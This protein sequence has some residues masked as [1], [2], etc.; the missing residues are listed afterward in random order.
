MHVIKYT[1]SDELHENIGLTIYA[2]T[3]IVKQG[4]VYSKLCI[5]YLFL[6]QL[7]C[8]D[9]VILPI[10]SSLWIKMNLRSSGCL[11]AIICC[12]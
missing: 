2:V 5:W 3:G 4:L 7:R 9:N 10:L 8:L 1:T 11:Y 6:S 12:V